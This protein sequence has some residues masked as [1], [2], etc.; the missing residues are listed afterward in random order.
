MK[1]LE[2]SF[3]SDKH[4]FQFE[5]LARTGNIAL[6]KKSLIEGT[7]YGFELIK[8]TSH[9]GYEMGGVWIEPAEMYPGN[10][11]WGVKGFSYT[12]E[13]FEQALEHFDRLVK[14]DRVKTEKDAL[15]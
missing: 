2:K 6:Y 4:K 12:Q 10:E 15:R 5:Q 3:V 14:Q 1:E 9:N 13:R 8:I 7:T 11:Q